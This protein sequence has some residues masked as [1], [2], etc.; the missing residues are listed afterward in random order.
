MMERLKDTAT[1]SGGGGSSTEPAPAK[2]R[3]MQ[4]KVVGV[5]RVTATMKPMQ[6]E[7]GIGVKAAEEIHGF[8]DTLLDKGR[9][10]LTGSFYSDMQQRK[11][12]F[13]YAVLRLAQEGDACVLCNSH[14]DTIYHSSYKQVM[15]P[16]LC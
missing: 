7:F 14:F 2:L 13:E 16:E 8:K 6:R 11:Q 12:A 9:K 10:I 3:A 5:R 1:T 4:P 15:I